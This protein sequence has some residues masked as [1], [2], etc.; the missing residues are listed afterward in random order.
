[1]KIILDLCDEETKADIA[2]NSSCEENTKTGDFIKFLIQMRRICNDTK[3]KTVFFG[4]QLSSITKHQCF[5][6]K[7]VKQILA[8]HLMDDD[9]WN[10]TN[11]CDVSLEDMSGIENLVNIDGTKESITTTTTLTSSVYDKI[12]YN[13]HEECDLQY[14]VPETMNNYQEWDDPLN[15]LEDTSHNYEFASDHI[16][17]DFYI[18]NRQT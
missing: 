4:S 13:T 12:W 16:K 3:D 15:I 18:D 11:P 8:T 1:M 17:Q 2:I 9:I 10:N 7:T 14:N 5:P 6:T